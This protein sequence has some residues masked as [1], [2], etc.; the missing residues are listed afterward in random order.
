MFFAAQ[1]VAR[2]LGIAEGYQL[3]FHVGKLGGQEVFHLHLHL[4]SD[5]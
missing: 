5:I 4:L 3:K 1:K 2:D